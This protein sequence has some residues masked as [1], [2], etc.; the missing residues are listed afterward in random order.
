M[1]PELIGTIVSSAGLLVT[2]GALIARLAGRVAAM[3]TTID[4]LKAEVGDIKD[5]HA[6]TRRETNELRERV[7]KLEVRAER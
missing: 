4:G 3:S 6:G 7:A 1:S 2:L 5:D